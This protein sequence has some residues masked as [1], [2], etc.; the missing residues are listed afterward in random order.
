MNR[1]SLAILCYFGFLVLSAAAEQPTAAK[2]GE[3]CGG[4]P[5]ILCEEGL[6]CSTAGICAKLVGEGEKCRG[7]DPVLCKAGLYCKWP[8]NT[9]AERAGAGQPCGGFA[10]VLCKEG[11]Q[12]SGPTGVCIG[13]N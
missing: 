5:P 2:W 7:K 12:C 10:A 8:D 1:I 13:A 4:T 6:E 11:L 3:K 9:C